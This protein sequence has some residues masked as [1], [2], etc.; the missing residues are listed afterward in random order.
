MEAI[1]CTPRIHI[2]RKKERIVDP[3]RYDECAADYVSGAL[4]PGDVKVA[5]A[6]ALNRLIQP[7]RDHFAKNE[8]AKKLLNQVRQYKSTR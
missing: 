2:P 5:V 6:R 1:K 8:E 3:R 4:H 7:V